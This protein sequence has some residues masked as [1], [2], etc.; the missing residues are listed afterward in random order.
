MQEQIELI[1]TLWLSND[2]FDE[3]MP[4]LIAQIY[5]KVSKGKTH[6]QVADLMGIPKHLVIKFG[7]YGTN[8]LSTLEKEKIKKRDGNKCRKCSLSETGNPSATLIVH[9]INSA[10]NNRPYNLITVCNFCHQGLHSLRSK[11]RVAYRELINNIKV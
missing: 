1:R 11:D 4:N 5:P 9:H 7:K 2:Y 3:R 8:H 10:K 6:Q